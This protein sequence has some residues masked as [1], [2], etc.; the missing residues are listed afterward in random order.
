MRL[1]A[2]LHALRSI[3]DW[4]GLNLQIMGLLSVLRWKI[5]CMLL[6]RIRLRF[7]V[8]TILPVRLWARTVTT[9]ARHINFYAWACHHMV[10]SRHSRRL[11]IQ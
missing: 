4:I 10:R 3:Q 11:V 7:I 2:R 8:Y 9:F 5:L 6:Q 1:F